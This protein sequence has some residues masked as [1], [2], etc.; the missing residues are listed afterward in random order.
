[1]TRGAMRK[2][3]RDGSV[4][5]RKIIPNLFTTA[6]LCSGLAS[7]HYANSEDWARALA[8]IGMSGILDMLD[9]RAA[10]LLKA[11]TQ[12]GE[13]FDSLSDFVCFGIAPAFLLYRWCR[14]DLSF[15]G[16]SLEGLLVITV[17]LFG[18]CS[19]LRL[20]RFTAQ[21]RRKPPGSKPSKFF[22]G[23]PT[24][25]AAGAA[26]I[27]PMLLLS[28]LQVRT[29]TLVVIVL[30]L[31][32]AGLMISRLPMF[33]FKRLRVHRDWAMPLMLLMAV[34]VGGFV[35][36]AWLT[37]SIL[38]AAYV[39]TLPLSIRAARRAPGLEAAKVGA[40]PSDAAGLA[41]EAQ[42]GDQSGRGR[43]E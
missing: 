3:L 1:M 4:P 25:A 24:P 27:P 14:H 11:T 39:A 21:Q 42:G 30:L 35:R 18:L 2:R 23:M 5:L 8:A 43:N 41:P 26:L 7:L 22:T 28:D 34:V 36:D 38:A 32:I 10:R 40:G 20:A 31:S 16:Y 9:G 29:P 12:F 15:M 33:A 19:A 37:M 6:A 17:V 13:A